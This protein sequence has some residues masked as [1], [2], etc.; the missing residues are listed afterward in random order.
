MK[1][2]GFAVALLAASFGGAAGAKTRALS[3]FDRVSASA[4]T[5]VVIIVGEGFAVDVDGSRPD[6]IVTRVEGRRLIVEPVRT[7]GFS[8]NSGSHSTV[9]VT[10]PAIA[11]LEASSG[12]DIRAT[13]LAAD[14]LSLDASSAGE[15]HVSGT[16]R[17]FNVSASS[18]AE[19]HA[20]DLRCAEGSVDASSGAEAS[21]W[22][23]GVLN[24]EA[25]SGADVN[26]KGSPR[27]GDISL[28]SG[29]ALH[30]D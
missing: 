16:C 30:H 3:G 9:R 7:W 12:A 18:G 13:G 27:L 5:D 8:W 4:G 17:S 22:A 21:V 6:R 20:G 25:S 10:M 19:V 28:S 1:I 24:V 11:G 14:A 29:G 2:L 26:A 23:E 15:I